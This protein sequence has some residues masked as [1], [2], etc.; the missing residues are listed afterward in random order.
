MIGASHNVLQDKTLDYEYL[1]LESR[2][3]GIHY[4]AVPPGKPPT[5]FRLATAT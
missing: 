3:D 1:R 4:V 2:A 5:D